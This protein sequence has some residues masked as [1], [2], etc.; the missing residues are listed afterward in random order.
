MTLIKPLYSLNADEQIVIDAVVK[1]AQKQHQVIRGDWSFGRVDTVVDTSTGYDGAFIA[2][3][4]WIGT[5]F[6]AMNT[7]EDHLDYAFAYYHWVSLNSPLVFY[8]VREI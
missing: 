6:R 3:I 2:L 5:V 4:K 7:N 8:F 1:P